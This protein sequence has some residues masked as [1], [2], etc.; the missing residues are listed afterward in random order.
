MREEER[1]VAI[2]VP[3]LERD[4]CQVRKQEHTRRYFKM[5]AEL[6][7]YEMDDVMLDLGF[8]LNILPKKS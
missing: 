1:I 8:N 5:I 2:S 6:R 7:S 3:L 4:V